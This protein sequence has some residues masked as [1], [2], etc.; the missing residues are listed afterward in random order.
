M[1]C[2]HPFESFFTISS[3]PCLDGLGLTSANIHLAI[4]AFHSWA[5][6]TENKGHLLI[7]DCT[8]CRLSKIAIECFSKVLNDYHLQKLIVPV[9]W[10]ALVGGSKD[11]ECVVLKFDSGASLSIHPHKLDYFND[12]GVI[13]LITP[14]KDIATPKKETDNELEAMSEAESTT[15]NSEAFKALSVHRSPNQN[16]VDSDGEVYEVDHGLPDDFQ[17]SQAW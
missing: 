6:E 11:V 4:N 7:V 2:L 13:D 9:E 1:S 3:L 10:V 16:Q 12:E 5:T 15:P 14:L 8:G 17:E